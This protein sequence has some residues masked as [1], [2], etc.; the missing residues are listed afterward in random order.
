MQ[1]TGRG[2]ACRAWEQKC[3]L[4]AF[5]KPDITNHPAFHWPELAHSHTILFLEEDRHHLYAVNFLETIPA[6]SLF[7]HH[8]LI[9]L[10]SPTSKGPFSVSTDPPLP[11]FFFLSTPTATTLLPSLCSLFAFAQMARAADQ[12]HRGRRKEGERERDEKK[13]QKNLYPKQLEQNTQLVQQA[14]ARSDGRSGEGGN[15]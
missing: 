13:K 2:L 9:P 5:W 12:S 15:M 14:A 8:V 1:P 6:L 7:R 10:S 3:K 4:I 11:H